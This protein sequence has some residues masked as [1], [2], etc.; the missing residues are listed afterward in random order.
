VYQYSVT[1][2][3]QPP[4]GRLPIDQRDFTE[5]VFPAS[6]RYGGGPNAV[7]R[8]V[9]FRS[10]Q[11]LFFRTFPASFDAFKFAHGSCRKWPGDKGVPPAVDVGKECRRWAGDPNEKIL[12][13]GPD[14]LEALGEW[15]PEKKWADWPRFF[16]HTGDQIYADDVGVAINGAIVRHQFASVVQVRSA[17]A[18]RTSRRR[19]YRRWRAGRPPERGA[20]TPG[21]SYGVRVA[22]RRSNFPTSTTRSRWRCA[23]AS[24]RRSRARPPQ[25]H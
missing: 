3:P 14:M 10:S 19:R 22:E 12:E 17:R 20:P 23:P 25:C 5:T 24:K 13:P 7:V 6:P 1:L 18:P 11:W 9:A 8:E 21:S 16:M 4:T 15:L 2:A